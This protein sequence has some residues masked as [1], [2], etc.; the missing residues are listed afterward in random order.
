MF[1]EGWMSGFC[2]RC[3]KIGLNAEEEEN[4]EDAD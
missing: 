3:K 4:A 1:S 2:S